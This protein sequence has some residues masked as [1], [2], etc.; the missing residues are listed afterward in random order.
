MPE[1][2]IL[3]VFPELF[4][5]SFPTFLG[6]Q[7]LLKT[8]SEN[9]Q[10]VLSKDLVI[11]KLFFIKHLLRLLKCFICGNEQFMKNNFCYFKL[12]VTFA[13]VEV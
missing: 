4:K 1:T 3:E 9:R 12:L 11:R 8:Q 2:N 10:S 5:R 7:N 13:S 6:F